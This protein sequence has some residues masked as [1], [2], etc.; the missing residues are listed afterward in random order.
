MLPLPTRKAVASVQRDVKELIQHQQHRK[1]PDL[2]AQINPVLQG[3]ANYFRIGNAKAAFQQVDTYVM[4]TF[5]P[6]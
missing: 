6:C 3:W 5:A 1:L 2:V 4:Y